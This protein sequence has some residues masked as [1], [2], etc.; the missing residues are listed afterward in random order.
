M[1]QKKNGTAFDIITFT[2]KKE[3][4]EKGSWMSWDFSVSRPATNEEILQARGWYDSM[5]RGTVK[6]HEDEPK[7]VAP[8][9]FDSDDLAF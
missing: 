6:H 7:E 5:Q 4:N 2:G 8:T 3:K 9:S 1:F